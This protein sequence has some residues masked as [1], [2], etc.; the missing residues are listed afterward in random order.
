MNINVKFSETSKWFKTAKE[1]PN[2]NLLV[3][4]KS[5]YLP[6]EKNYA[7]LVDTKHGMNWLYFGSDSNNEAK[8][9]PFDYISEWRWI[10]P[11]EMSKEFEEVKKIIKEHFNEAPCGLFFCRNA[12]SDEM[13]NIYDKNGIQIDICYNYE[14]FE[15]FGLDLVQQLV[16]KKYYDFLYY[17]KYKVQKEF[18]SE[19]QVE[20]F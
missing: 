17:S 15:I 10:E 2:I 3:E 13:T 5:D 8:I 20:W 7:S 4:V 9:I 19:W 18:K 1:L 16:L 6:N 11:A 12:A 14:Y